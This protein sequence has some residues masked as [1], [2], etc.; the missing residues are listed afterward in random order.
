MKISILILIHKFSTQQQLL[1]KH[2]A[3][4]FEIF[5]HIDKKS[6]ISLRDLNFP[7]VYAYKKY[8]VF[9]GSYNQILATLFLFKMAYNYGINRYI[10][11]SGE[12]IPLKANTEISQFFQNDRNNYLSIASLPYSDWTVTNGD[13][14]RVDY[15]WLNSYER[16]YIKSQIM[17]KLINLSSRINDAFINFCKHR[18]LKRKLS[19]Q[20]QLL[21]GANWM[22]LT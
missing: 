14:D 10:L 3:K 19:N 11:I 1:I 15:F 2:L 21:G 13:L 18:K 12:D 16:V 4:D 20:I 9:W 8:K 6:D 22:D 5:V 7:N 17:R